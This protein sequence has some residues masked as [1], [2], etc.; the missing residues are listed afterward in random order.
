MSYAS[1][2]LQRKFGLGQQY[3]PD[4]LKYFAA[5]GITPAS[6]TPTAYDQAATF[7]GSNQYL[8][9]ASNSSLQLGATNFTI[10]AWINP[11]SYNGW[12][13]GKYDHSTGMEYGIIVNSSAVIQIQLGNTVFSIISSIPLNQWSLITVVYN[14]S[15]LN[16]YLNGSSVF[17]SFGSYGFTNNSAPFS[18][19]QVGNYSSSYFNGSIAGVGIWNSDLNSAQ[20]SALYNKGI[21]LTYS[22]IGDSDLEP[23]LVSYWA[24]NETSG[25]SVYVD[26]N[27]IN[28]LTPYNTPTNSVGP[29][30]T[31]TLPTQNL[32]N[33]FVKG[34]KQ[35]G[36]WNS[37]VCWPL[38]SS[39]NA[40]STL[41]AYSLG[42]YGN[43]NGNLVNVGT[44]YSSQGIVASTSGGVNLG[45]PFN[46]AQI[47]AVVEKQASPPSTGTLLGS[48]SVSGSTEYGYENLTDGTN[49]YGRFYTSNGSGGYSSN[50]INAPITINNSN[51][52]Y[53]QIYTDNTS[54]GTGVNNQLSALTAMA[55]TTRLNSTNNLFLGARYSGNNQIA[56]TY[57][58]AMIVNA[59][60]SSAPLNLYNLYKSTLGV[61]LSLP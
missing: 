31:A 38:R 14:G 61:G 59:Y 13:L 49:V 53:V 1:T 39:Q 22:V 17:V 36:L 41:T 24:L 57:P 34:T 2:V 3:D 50:T 30:A 37:M 44:S 21:G 5:A 19:G 42:G 51:F 45:S 7:N 26:S 25:A 8:S 43:F 54:N 58:F 16:A 23:Y 12:I 29:I 10:S 32:I 6:A 18:I 47:C 27:E 40:S 52:N 35:L 20:V 11:S 28:N 48:Y 56:G 15:T 33:S 46:S 55:T 60:N 4:A 9:V